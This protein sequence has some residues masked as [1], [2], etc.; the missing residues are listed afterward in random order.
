MLLMQICKYKT[1]YTLYGSVK[2]AVKSCV[3][4]IVF[5]V[6]LSRLFT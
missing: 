2:F 5:F 4:S 6:L 3:A 1:L